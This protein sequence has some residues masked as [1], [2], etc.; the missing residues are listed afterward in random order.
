MNTSAGHRSTNHSFCFSSRL[1]GNVLVSS[2]GDPLHPD[3]Y[4][5]PEPAQKR[6]AL[7]LYQSIAGLPLVCPHAH[8]DPRLF[9]Q[10]NVTFPTPPELFTIPDH[11]AFRILNSQGGPLKALRFPRAD[12]PPV[13]A[14]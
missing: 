10:P 5:S 14:D 3:R 4:F 2:E 11:S 8:V 7:E 6:I 13:Q 1:C 12:A 9:A